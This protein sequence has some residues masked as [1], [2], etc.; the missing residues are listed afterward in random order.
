MA[1]TKKIIGYRFQI[2]YFRPD[3]LRR[4]IES[5]PY[6]GYPTREECEASALRC[7]HFVEDKRGGIRVQLGFEPTIVIEKGAQ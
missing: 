3:T 5:S 2:S 4:Y 7:K 1:T 6:P